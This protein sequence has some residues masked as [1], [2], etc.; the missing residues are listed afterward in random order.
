MFDVRGGDG[1]ASTGGGGSGG[2]TAVY[3]KTS[4]FHF[5]YTL[6]GGSGKKVG[7]S[8]FL[9]SKTTQTQAEQSELILQGGG[10]LAFESPSLLVCDPQQIDYT[11][12]KITL[13]KSSTLSMVSCSP[14]AVSYTHLTLP[15]KRIV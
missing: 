12:D 14:G 1:G 11:F 10:V 4:P 15:T 13:L 9:Y 8:G 3:C 5:S 6:H 2:I 7:A